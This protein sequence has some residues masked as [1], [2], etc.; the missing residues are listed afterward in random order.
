MRGSGN[1]R[2]RII[3]YVRQGVDNRGEEK[4]K[5]VEQLSKGGISRML[6]GSIPNMF[7]SLSQGQTLPF[8]PLPLFHKISYYQLSSS[9]YQSYYSRL[10]VTKGRG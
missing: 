9:S 4:R 8:S 5:P 7:A 2:Q 6:P 10:L 1:P 3:G